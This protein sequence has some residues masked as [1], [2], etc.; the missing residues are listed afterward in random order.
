M[1]KE[2]IN[3]QKIT[4][5]HP[6]IRYIIGLKVNTMNW[7]RAVAYQINPYKFFKLTMIN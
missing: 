4:E 3:I 2:G 7:E 6:L 5:R 1:S